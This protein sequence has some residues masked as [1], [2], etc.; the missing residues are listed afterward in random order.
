MYKSTINKT[1]NTYFQS[2][3]NI[4]TKRLT[5]NVDVRQVH[6]ASWS[7]LWQKYPSLYIVPTKSV[8]EC[9]DECFCYTWGV[10]SLEWIDKYGIGKTWDGHGEKVFVMESNKTRE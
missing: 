10:T 9:Y 4:L 2:N 8:G 6:M 7:A 3:T 1:T 5:I